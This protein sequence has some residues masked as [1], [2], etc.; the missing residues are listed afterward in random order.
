MSRGLN[1]RRILAGAAAVS[2]MGALAGVPAAAVLAKDDERRAEIIGT[3]FI[4]VTPAGQNV[5]KFNVLAN[6]NGD[7]GSVATTSND[8]APGSRGSVGFGAWVRT[9]RNTFF[10]N[11]MGFVLDDSGRAV[12][13]AHVRE[14]VTIDATGTYHG[15]AT[16]E[17]DGLDG[18]VIF[19]ATS[20]ALGKRVV[21]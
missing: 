14:A 19:T 6:F 2:G 15:V 18:H 9:G 13:I 7:G 11:G 5:P 12:G 8:S 1:R 3:W 16:L 10:G 21:A 20:T 4:T 17:V